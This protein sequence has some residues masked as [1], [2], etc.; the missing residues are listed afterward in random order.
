MT[1]ETQMNTHCRYLNTVEKGCDAA[2][3]TSIL[4]GTYLKYYCCKETFAL[5]FFLTFL[6]DYVEKICR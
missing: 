3:V 5:F 4:Q 1:K 2:F 6:V